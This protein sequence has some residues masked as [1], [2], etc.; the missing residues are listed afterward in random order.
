MMEGQILATLRTW[1]D[2]M[3]ECDTRLDELAAL[4]GPIVE[5]PLGDAIYRLMGCYTDATAD[6]I[7]WDESILTSWWCEHNFG[8]RPMKIGFCGEPMQSIDTID[9]LAK[10][11]AEDLR[12]SP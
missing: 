11:I 10:F 3:Q 9:A 4:T 7:G 1:Q 5:S 6:L 2:A 8:E 12:R